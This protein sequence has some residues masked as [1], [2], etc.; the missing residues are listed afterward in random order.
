MAPADLTTIRRLLDDAFDGEFADEDWDHALGGVH[1]VVREDG[2]IVAHACVVQ[3][4]LIHR[5]LA[6]RTGYVE[7]LAVNKAHRRRGHAEA[8]MTASERVIRAAYDL[9]ALSDGTG[10]QDFYQ[11]R[12]WLTWSGPTWVLA[13]TGMERTADDD[14]GV[15]VLPTPTSPELDLDDAITCDWRTGDVW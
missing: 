2:V 3:R 8:A 9:G 13:P 14:G 4:R 12:G 15:L 1:V 5:G 11:R 7:A 10:I 6:I